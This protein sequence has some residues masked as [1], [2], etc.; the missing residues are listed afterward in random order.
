MKVELPR[1]SKKEK[2]SDFPDKFNRVMEGLENNINEFNDKIEST[3]KA[4]DTINSR[5]DYFYG[6][7]IEIFGIFIAI[8]SL[9]IVTGYNI[10]IVEG[11]STTETVL[12]VFY[13]LLPL[14]VILV[15]FVVL[16]NWLRKK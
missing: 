10:S 12:N 6:R 4:V 14:T 16:L 3:Q 15:L 8:F 1:L 7:I 11:E 9:I 13:F 5:L 2:V